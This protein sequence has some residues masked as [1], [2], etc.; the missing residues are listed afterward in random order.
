MA[1]L[2]GGDV[3]TIPL[4]ILNGASLTEEVDLGAAAS[5]SVIMPTAWTAANITIVV[6][7]PGV[8]DY[9]SVYKDDGTEYV[10]TAAVDRAIT[11]DAAIFAIA[12]SRKI[13]LRSGTE[14]TPVNQGADRT[15]FLTIKR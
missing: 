12:G 15:L 2:R 13:K 9:V 3:A 1:S 7:R 11:L 14:A 8:Q 4:K 5:A 10:L 6:Y